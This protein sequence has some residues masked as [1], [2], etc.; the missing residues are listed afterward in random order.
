MK[1]KEIAEMSN[2]EL[3]AE[4]SVDKTSHLFDAFFVGFLIGIIIFS[5]A[6]SSW[7]LTTLIPL[8]LIRAVVKQS[9]RKKAVEQA[10]KERGLQ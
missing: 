1:P 9:G 3:I 6:V 5:V 2:E 7:G 10:M 8:F 4:A